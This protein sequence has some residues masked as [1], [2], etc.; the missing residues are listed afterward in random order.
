MVQLD[1]VD[2]QHVREV[3]IRQCETKATS[4]YAGG[5]SLSNAMARRSVPASVDVAALDVWFGGRPLATNLHGH[6]EA[7]VHPFDVREPDGLQV[8][9]YVSA[10]AQL[11]GVAMTA[12]ALTTL[13]PSSD[14][15]FARAGRGRWTLSTSSWTTASSSTARVSGRSRLNTK[16]VIGKLVF[17][18]PVRVESPRRGIPP[19]P[20]TRAAPIAVSRRLRPRWPTRRRL[21][22]RS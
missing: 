14:V 4:A 11:R 19:V 6:V 16:L 8:L 7:T 20:S 10:T 5:G 2:V 18:A 17:E 21:R 3:W 9:R 15:G 13:L 12:N 1:D 22:R